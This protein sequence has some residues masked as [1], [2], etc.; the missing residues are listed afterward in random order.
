MNSKITSNLAGIELDKYYSIFL[1]AMATMVQNF[2][3]RIVNNAGDALIYYFP[4]TADS[5]NIS[6]FNDV[7]ECDITV[8]AAY[9]TINSR[10]QAEKD[11]HH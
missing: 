6:T 2:G 11:Y 9:R 1:N 4:D 7:L 8:I 10:M 3:A 5:S